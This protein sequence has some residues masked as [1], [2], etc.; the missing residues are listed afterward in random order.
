MEGVVIILHQ[1][2]FDSTS[3][4]VKPCDANVLDT[5]TGT[6]LKWGYISLKDTG[7]DIVQ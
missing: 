6:T 4:A 1:L 5:G 7:S 3:V 2:S